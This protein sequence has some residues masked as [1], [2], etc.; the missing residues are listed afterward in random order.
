MLGLDLII[1]AI[2]NLTANCN[3]MY[4][5][6]LVMKQEKWR[7]QNSKL[8]IWWNFDILLPTPTQLHRGF[9]QRR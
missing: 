3:T 7:H 9:F 6:M 4:V 5:R 1:L 2:N 8:F